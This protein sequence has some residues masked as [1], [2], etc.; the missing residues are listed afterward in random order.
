MAYA[1]KISVKKHIND[2]QRLFRLDK[3]S[4]KHED[5]CIVMLTRQRREFS[6]P[7]QCRTDTLMLVKSHAD[8][9][10]AATQSYPGIHSAIFDSR[11][12][13][14]REIRIITT[15]GRHRSEILIRDTPTLEITLNYTF[16][17]VAGMV[18]TQPDRHTGMKNTCHTF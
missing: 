10:T 8:T 3:P 4:R 17:F 14:M 13:R 11:S 7:A 18:R 1:L 9:V 6:V 5:I 15:V 16:H 2:I 12:T